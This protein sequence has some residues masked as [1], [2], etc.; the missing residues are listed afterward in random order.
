MTYSRSLWTRARALWQRARHSA[1]GAR[2]RLTDA[3]VRACLI[4]GLLGHSLG[5][6]RG[7]M[8][9]DD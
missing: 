5:A 8:A 4:V 1:N 7:R 3:R 6:A 2:R 9:N